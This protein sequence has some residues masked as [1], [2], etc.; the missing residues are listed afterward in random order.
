MSGRP[1]TPPQ[2]NAPSTLPQPPLTP[3]QVRKLEIDRLK[4]KALRNQNPPP[5]AQTTPSGFLAGQKRPHSSISSAHSA[6]PN[7]R[8]ARRPS[9]SPPQGAA[10]QAKDDGIRPAK[11]F[12]KY[13]DYDFSKMTDTKGGFLSST[14]DPYNKALHAPEKGEQRPAHMTLAEWERHQLL[15]TLRAQRAGPFEPGISAFSTDAKKCHDCG[16]L[17]IDFKWDDI[18]NC[19]VC[20]LCKEKFPDKYSLL[21]KT[22]ARED[23][24]LTDPELKDEKLLPHL[25]RPNPHKSTWNNM[26]LYLRYQIEAYA[27]SERK[28]GSAEALDA[29]FERRQ[30]QTRQRKEKKFNEKLEEL[31]KRTR[32]EAYRRARAKGEDGPKAQFGDQVGSKGRHEH[33]WGR[34]VEDPETGVSKKTCAECGM[35]VEEVEF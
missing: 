23:Y 8:D 11:K 28:W 22:E 15:K 19:Q 17:E 3:E 24:L 32:V 30:A 7:Q 1:S 14:D 21:T 33:E 25:D 27:F 29:E 6:K 34:S 20:N 35:E 10:A 4:A 26:Q 16:S 2:L 31:K 5:A 13:I 9:H 12:E 18:F